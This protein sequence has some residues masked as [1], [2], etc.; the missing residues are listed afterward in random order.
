MTNPTGDMYQHRALN[1][2]FAGVGM[3]VLGIA[4]SFISVW[5][6]L[7]LAALGIALLLANVARTLGAIA[8]YLTTTRP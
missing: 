7:L 2:S 8:D 3:V 1:A 6:G 5:I 4:A